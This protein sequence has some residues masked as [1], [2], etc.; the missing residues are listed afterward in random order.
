MNGVF[1]CYVVELGE[2]LIDS[3][4]DGITFGNGLGHKVHWEDVDSSIP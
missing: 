3:G 2:V 1:C 4:A